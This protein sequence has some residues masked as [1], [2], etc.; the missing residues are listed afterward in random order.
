MK[1]EL[2]FFIKIEILKIIY[3]EIVY[4]ILDFLG[5]EFEKNINGDI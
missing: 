3:I 1:W 2:D 5:K 4:L